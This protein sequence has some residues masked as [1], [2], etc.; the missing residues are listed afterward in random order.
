MAGVNPILPPVTADEVQ[1]DPFVVNQKI[2]TI[3]AEVDAI[4]PST[5]TVNQELGETIIT[6]VVPEFKWLG[7]AIRNATTTATNIV[8]NATSRG[9]IYFMLFVVHSETSVDRIAFRC[10]VASASV[11]IRL[12]IY[13]E[14]NGRPDTLLVDAGTV[15]I[16]T[17]GVKDRPLI[18]PVTLAPG[19]YYVA[20]VVQ[21]AATNTGAITAKTVNSPAT[22]RWHDNSGS[23]MGDSAAFNPAFYTTATT[24]T[25]G[26]FPANTTNGDILN[27]DLTGVGLSIYPAVS[28]R[29][30]NYPGDL[31]D[32]DAFDHRTV[33]PPLAG[34]TGGNGSKIYWM[35]ETS[36]LVNE[37]NLATGI[38]GTQL[39]PPVGYTAALTQKITYADSALWLVLCPVSVSFAKVD[40]LAYYNGSGF[41]QISNNTIINQAYGLV[42]T[43]T[44]PYVGMHD[45]YAAHAKDDKLYVVLT[46][47]AAANDKIAIINKTGVVSTIDIPVTLPSIT[48]FNHGHVL[49]NGQHIWVVARPASGSTNVIYYNGTTWSSVF[50]VG[51]TTADGASMVCPNGDLLFGGG[52]IRRVTTAGVVTVLANPVYSSYPYA[53]SGTKVLLTR[54]GSHIS[55]TSTKF[56]YDSS[57]GLLTSAYTQPTN[58]NYY[59]DRLCPVTYNG[60]WLAVRQGS[61]TAGGDDRVVEVLTYPV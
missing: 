4:Q 36:N 53:V 26:A 47:G 29:S 9:R 54:V 18:A 50:S 37:Y 27:V 19:R 22:H 58:L 8:N 56:V 41:T 51:N 21:S 6:P 33:S 30:G 46:H 45:S 17:T 32:T 20:C 55:T 60:N 23:A 39:T 59:E 52:E 49:V 44:S 7:P 3:Q 34:P 61:F 16:S 42:G 15:T 38:F 14:V 48:N 2:D 12:G 43:A 25:S 28:V 24:Y 13:D 31:V 10:A 1:F 40:G 57:T 5:T 35:D 11:Q